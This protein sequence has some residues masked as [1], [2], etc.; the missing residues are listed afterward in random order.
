EPYG[1]Y[2]PRRRA[3]IEPFHGKSRFMAHGATKQL[4]ILPCARRRGSYG[5]WISEW[6]S[7]ELYFLLAK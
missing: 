1:P 2:E 7:H 4:D 5:P 6:A 3:N